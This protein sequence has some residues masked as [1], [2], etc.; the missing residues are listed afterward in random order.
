MTLLLPWVQRA[1]NCDCLVPRNRC[2][3]DLAA[4]AM[5]DRFIAEECPV[6]VQTARRSHLLLLPP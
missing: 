4:N 3:D 2:Q 5:V 1:T 6:V